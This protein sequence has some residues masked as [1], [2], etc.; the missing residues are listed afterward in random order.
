M[1]ADLRTIFH[2]ISDLILLYYPITVDIRY[3][4]HVSLNRLLFNDCSLRKEWEKD[5]IISNNYVLS[6]FIKSVLR[7]KR[8]RK[9]IIAVLMYE[10]DRLL[11]YEINKE[12]YDAGY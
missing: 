3:Q 1:I 8:F 6:G 2:L 4:F 9:N 10:R 12:N 7:K 11:E 5:V